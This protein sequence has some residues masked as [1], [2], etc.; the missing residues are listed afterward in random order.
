LWLE[1]KL[2]MCDDCLKS[3][4]HDAGLGKVADDSNKDCDGIRTC[5]YCG[6]NVLYIIIIVGTVGLI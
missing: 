1:K 6:K 2:E 5:G 4:A 3:M